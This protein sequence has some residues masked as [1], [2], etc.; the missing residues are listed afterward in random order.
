MQ[1]VGEGERFP[2]LRLQSVEGPIRLRDLWRQGPT[3]V[4]FMRHFGCSFCREHLTALADADDRVAAAGGRT[5][6]IF[7]YDAEATRS[8]CDGRSIPFDC[9]GDPQREAYGRIGLGRGSL[10]E[11]MGWSVIKRG[12]A[13][14]RAGGGQGSAEGGSIALMPGSFVLDRE[15]R[16]VL[17]HYNRNAADNPPVD[18]LI[19]AVAAAA[20]A[21]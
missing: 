15:G 14:Y 13:A 9:L 20:A 12:R 18:L 2:D 19:G 1:R 21:G 7:Q 5:V 8:F 10:R 3:I 4:T 17:A 16:I 6:A 11:L